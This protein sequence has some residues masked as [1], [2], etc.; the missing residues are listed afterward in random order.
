MPVGYGAI[1]LLIGR[2]GP[3]A[4]TRDRRRPIERAGAG[5]PAM[6][7]MGLR[8]PSAARLATQTPAEVVQLLPRMI[9]ADQCQD[10]QLDRMLAG[11]THRMQHRLRPE[12]A[13]RTN[14]DRLLGRVNAA[15]PRAQ[16]TYG[17]APTSR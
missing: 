1:V 8:M 10:I 6:H 16:A 17:S 9:A 2:R 4:I 15:A 5:I 3:R 11:F 14:Y 13:E 12:I 7:Q